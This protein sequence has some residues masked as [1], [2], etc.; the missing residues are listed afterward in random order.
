MVEEVPDLL[1]RLNDAL[2]RD[3][4]TPYRLGLAPPDELKPA[5]KNARFMRHETYA[6]LVE[7]IQRDG[8]LSSLPFCWKSGDAFYILSGHHRV[9]AAR[10]AGVRLILFLYTDAAL[11]EAERTAIQ[12]SHNA[13]VG[14]DNL[15][16]LKELYESLESYDAKAYSGLDDKTIGL[17]AEIAP[18]T[19][20]EAHLDF[21]QVNLLFLPAEVEALDKLVERLRA[22]RGDA[23]TYAAHLADWPAFWEMLLRFKDAAKIVNTATAL[24]EIIRI[25]TE[26]LDALEAQAAGSEQCA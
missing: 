2:A 6:R 4:I 26:H 3:G 24:V 8:N 22:T 25:V 20:Q 11:T 15:A 18:A 10:Q 13:L 19:F 7:N 23:R 5:P 21:E 14:E 16:I 1:G 9:D 17:L 12:L